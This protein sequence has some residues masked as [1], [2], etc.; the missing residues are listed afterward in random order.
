MKKSFLLAAALAT[1]AVPALAHD[2]HH[3]MSANTDSGT[4][5][6]ASNANSA[7]QPSTGS[8]ETAGAN[9]QGNASTAIDPEKADGNGNMSPSA[10]TEGSGAR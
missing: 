6:M 9:Y 10:R 7:A 3:K 8:T 4:A 5:T 1:L 2:T